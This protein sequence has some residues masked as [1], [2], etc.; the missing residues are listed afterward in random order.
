MRQS[1]TAAV[2]SAKGFGRVLPLAQMPPAT[3]E[4]WGSGSGPHPDARLAA[5][6][7]LA[8]A[9]GDCDDEA[10]AVRVACGIDVCGEAVAAESVAPVGDA[11]GGAVEPQ[12]RLMAPATTSRT[13]DRPRRTVISSIPDAIPVGTNPADLRF[14]SLAG[15][16]PVK[17][18]ANRSARSALSPLSSCRKKT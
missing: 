5:G 16:Q 9:P 15:D 8:A 3:P 12:A 10:S 17:S 14:P 4:G 13:A 7:A 11:A 2:V 1:I 6:E 18:P